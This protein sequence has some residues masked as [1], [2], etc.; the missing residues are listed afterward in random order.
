MDTENF[1]IANHTKGKLTSLPFVNI[2]KEIKDEILG[3]HYS[4]SIAF[5]PKKYSH[6]INKKYRNKDKPTN[7]LSFALSKTSGELILS[8]TVIR[9]EVK[10]KKFDKNFRELVQFLII[11]GMLHLKGFDHGEKMEKLEKKYL[12]RTKF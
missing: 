11:H 10:L 3:T 4:L 12:S 7:V 2:L 6:E 9:E 8:P 1:S 5:V